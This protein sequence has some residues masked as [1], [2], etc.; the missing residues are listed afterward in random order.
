MSRIPHTHRR[1]GRYVFR[2]RI[3]FQ[4]LISKPLA[5][6]LQTADPK[7]ARERAAL[8]SARFALVKAGVE[9]IMEFG[10]SLTG[11]QIEDLFRTEL[12]SELRCHV[13]RAFEDTEWS[14]KAL[15]LAAEDRVVY[16]HLTSADR[17]A[18]ELRDYAKAAIPDEWIAQKL[19]SIGAL[20]DPGSIAAARTH[21]FRARAAAGSLVQRLF[22]E[23]VLDEV[24]PVQALMGSREPRSEGAFE[25]RHEMTGSP[26][27]PV[28]PDH[29]PHCEFRIYDV[30]RFGD[31]IDE[32]IAELKFEG[33]WKSGFEQKRRIMQTFAWL[34]GNRELGS[35]DHRDVSVFKSALTKLPVTFR[36][37][38][39]TE[40]AM[41]RPFD[42]VLAKLP[43]LDASQRRNMKTINRDL[44]TMSTVAKHLEQ[45]AWKSKIPGARVM[46]FSG[47][48]VAIR[49]DDSTELR[50]AWTTAHLKCLFDSPL[51]TGG[52]GG[53]KRLKAGESN[54]HVWHDAA[55]FAPLLWYYTHACRE[56]ICGLE[57]ADVKRD[58]PVPHIHIRDNFT[59]GR[60]G[61][62]A[63]EKRKARNRKLPIHPELIRLG[64]LD[65]VRAICAEGHAALFPELYLFKA[66]RGGAQFYDRAW[67]YMV[68]WIG[69][70]MPLPSN[71]KGK[72]PDIH[73]IRSLGSSF[74][75]VDGVN[76]IMRADMMGHARQGTNARHYSKRTQT[77]GI[78]VVLAERL[79]FLKRYVPEITQ[80]VGAIP[81]RLLPIELRSRVGSGR[82][83]KTRN[84]TGSR[85]PT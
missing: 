47:A 54:P 84:D 43:P 33:V 32:V 12:E 10:G 81:I 78:E 82:H 20:T 13:Q 64:F 27:S 61:E 18:P 58:H 44:S 48:T 71:D 72:G 57:V 24:D 21:L 53:K 51:Y 46:D 19:T 60:D 55:Y 66:K 40:G 2:R 83:R 69:D 25:H 50:P 23:D 22:D 36:Y 80:H 56:E 3:H 9:K 7:I 74:Y 85:K 67:R 76:E 42:E 11:T 68:E 77:E 39:L 75:E 34:T 29:A 26:P 31:V 15:E 73:S 45:T 17:F 41:S 30:R 63:G 52:G 4:N 70:Q 38:S 5:I 62:K 6:A 65:Y 16:R 37:G 28:I 79:D 35:Y 1:V 59:R 49:E 8:L 14:D